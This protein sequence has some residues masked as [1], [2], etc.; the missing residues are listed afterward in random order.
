MWNN[1]FKYIDIYLE[2]IYILDGNVV[3][4]QV[5]CD[6]F[7]E[8]IKVVG[9]IELF[10]GGI[11]FDGYIVFNELGFSLVF[12]I[13]VKM[14]VMDI[15]LVNVRFFDGEFIKVFIMVLM[16]GVGIVMDVREVMIFIIGVYKVFVLYKVIEEGVNYMW[17]V[18]VFQQY[19]CIVFVC[20]EDVILELKVKIVKYF[21]GLMFVYNKLV[22]FL[23]SI[24]EKEIEK[25]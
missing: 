25:S 18:F 10:V 9:G 12:R 22:D 15:I 8:K 11:G 16:V 1:F 4:L 17:I 5:E 13:C 19:F 6:V 21:K 23:Y 7:E 14:L 3:D 2:N 24:K 20:D